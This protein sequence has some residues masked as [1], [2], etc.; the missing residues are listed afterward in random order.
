MRFTLPTP[1]DPIDWII[2]CRDD[3]LVIPTPFEY[4]ILSPWVGILEDLFRKNF[5]SLSLGNRLGFSH[6]S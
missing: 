3:R 4:K 2:C 6:T 1:S 5:I